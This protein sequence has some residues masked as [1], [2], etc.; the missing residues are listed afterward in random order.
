MVLQLDVPNLFSVWTVQQGKNY[1][2]EVWV[3]TELPAKG[4]AA[5]ARPPHIFLCITQEHATRQEIFKSNLELIRQHNSEDHT[6]KV[7]AP[8]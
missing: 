8:T 3:T 7:L 2:A 1:T 5:E 6:Y 4:K